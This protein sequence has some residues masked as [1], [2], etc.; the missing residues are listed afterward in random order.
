VIEDDEESPTDGLAIQLIPPAKADT[1]ND[2]PIG[3]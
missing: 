3:Y 1:R 2:E